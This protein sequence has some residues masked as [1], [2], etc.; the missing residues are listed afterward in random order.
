MRFGTRAL[1]WSA[2]AQLWSVG[3]YSL[4]HV[5]PAGV[6]VIDGRVAH[7]VALTVAQIG[8]GVVRINETGPRVVGALPMSDVDETVCGGVS[9]QVFGFIGGACAEP[10]IVRE[11]GTSSLR[12]NDS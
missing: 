9:G 6:V 12:V 10:V 7:R 5:S 11:R 4:P 3:H 2:C 8:P 1:P